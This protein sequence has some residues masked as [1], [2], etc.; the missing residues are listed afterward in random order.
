M[1]AAK[2]VNKLTTFAFAQQLKPEYWPGLTDDEKRVKEDKRARR[3]VAKQKRIEKLEK[4]ILEV[5]YENL[6]E[7]SLDKVHADK[8]LSDE[9][10]AELEEMRKQAMRKEKDKPVQMSIFDFP[11]VMP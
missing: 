7:Y 9:R 2:K 11:E 6:E 1:A 3:E 5:G 10:I 4:K 8:W